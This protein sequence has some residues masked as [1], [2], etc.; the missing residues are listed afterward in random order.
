MTDLTRAGAILTALADPTRRAVLDRLRG[1]ALPVALIAEPLPV[2]RPAVSQ[3]L[4]VLLDA[5][6]VTMEAQ[7]TRHLYALAPGGA[8]PLTEWLG[9]LAPEG[10]DDEIH[11]L[12]VR[13]TPEEAWRLFL[14]DIAIWWPVAELSYSALRAGAL[15]QAVIRV[16]DRLRETAFDGAQLD[17]AAID[18]AQP[19]ERL[20][21]DWRL[22]LR[23]RLTVRFTPDPE[24]CRVV[25]D[26]GGA[27]A[28]T[29]P[30]L[31]LERYG[32]AAR[33]SLSNF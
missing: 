10:L 22:G 26:W 32:A 24:G 5:G 6:L 13:L 4:K 7:G 19:P 33:A 25:F 11:A 3:H 9:A 8:Q 23:T 14:D 18:T 17:W 12:T 16:G 30:E 28:G 29:V 15:P 20:V 27:D 31:V 1:G 21:L 2:T